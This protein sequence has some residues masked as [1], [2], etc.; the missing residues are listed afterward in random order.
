MNLPFFIYQIALLVIINLF[1]LKKGGFFIISQFFLALLFIVEFICYKKFSSGIS[2][3]LIYNWWFPVEFIFYSFFLIKGNIKNKYFNLTLVLSLIY[4]VFILIYYSFF[5]NQKLF[6]SISYQL[7]EFLLL[8][9]IALQIRNILKKEHLVN[10]FTNP[11]VWLIIGLLFSNLGSLMHLSATNY[12][13]VQDINLLN[14]LRKLN[15]ILTIV[16]YCCITVYFYLEWKN[17][18]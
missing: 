6:S 13:A 9:L 11:L 4:L 2:T 1:F 7:G 3:N 15:I 8:F 16:L 14:A 17:Q 18:K 12:L 10:P 5:Q